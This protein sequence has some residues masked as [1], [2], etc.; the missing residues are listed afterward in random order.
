MC[1]QIQRAEPGDEAQLDLGMKTVGCI[2][3]TRHK[4][5]GADR[6]LVVEYEFD[7]DQDP[8]LLLERVKKAVSRV[9]RQYAIIQGTNEILNSYGLRTYQR[10]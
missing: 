3:I 7:D 1:V 4:T 10:R 8:S 6:K 9:A 2:C 5:E